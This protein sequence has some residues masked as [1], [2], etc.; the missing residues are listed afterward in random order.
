M[1]IFAAIVAAGAG[2][3]LG[4]RNKAALTLPNGRSFLANIVASCRA[5]GVVDVVVV[6]RAGQELPRDLEAP[7]IMAT[8]PAPERLGMLGSIHAALATQVGQASCAM[9]LWP[10][11]CPRV[12]E[13]CLRTLLQAAAAGDHEIVLPRIGTRRG[14]PALFKRTVYEELMRAPLDQ[15]ARA[16]VRAQPQRVLEVAVEEA[17][18]TDDID[19][20]ADLSRLRDAGSVSLRSDS[21]QGGGDSVP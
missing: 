9:L 8:N 13:S 2:R 20:L 6:L 11:D 14:H 1:K 5:V 17:S 3:R 15:G 12:S 10:V 18:V 21:S 16:V 4:G 7:V 19:T